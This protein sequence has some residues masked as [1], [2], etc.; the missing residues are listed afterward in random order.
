[1]NRKQNLKPLGSQSHR[2]YISGAKSKNFMW[3][4]ITKFL[5]LFVACRDIYP[6]GYAFKYPVIPGL[7][8]RLLP[9][10]TSMITKDCITDQHHKHLSH[11]THLSRN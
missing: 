2:F 11:L 4:A 5:R 3:N 9:L 1:M 7:L 8:S 6:C 10:K